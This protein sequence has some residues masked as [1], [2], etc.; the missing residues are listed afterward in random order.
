MITGIILARNS[1]LIIARAISCLRKFDEILVYDTGSIDRTIEVAKMFGVR[2]E[3]VEFKEGYAKMRN[4]AA[5]AAKNPYVFHLDT[6]EVIN[7]DVYDELKQ[8]L[9]G[10]TYACV[11]FNRYN[12]YDLKNYVKAWYP[13]EQWR[14]Y[15]KNICKYEKNVH[16]ELKRKNQLGCTS[17]FPILHNMFFERKRLELNQRFYSQVAGIECSKETARQRVDEYQKKPTEKL[18]LSERGNK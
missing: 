12:M 10:G 5:A 1:E 18:C 9:G 2:V 14:A 13:D 17:L 8:I 4:D 11:G 7:A 6:D 16:E 3:R 15:N